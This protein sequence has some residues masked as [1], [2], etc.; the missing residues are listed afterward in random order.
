[1]ND[2]LL[3]KK[4]AKEVAQAIYAD[5]KKYAL[6][7]SDRYI[8]W[9]LSEEHKSKGKLPPQYVGDFLF[10]CPHC[11]RTRCAS[12]YGQAKYPQKTKKEATK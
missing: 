2:I 12:V 4:Q 7:N 8:P 6:N 10:S 1:M 9:W 5:I 11:G 3:N